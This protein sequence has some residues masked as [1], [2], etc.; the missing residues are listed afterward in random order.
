M[1]ATEGGRIDYVKSLIELGVDVDITDND[2][3]T[4]RDLAEQLDHQAIARLLE[5]REDGDWQKC[6]ELERLVKQLSAQ[7]SRGK[8]TLDSHLGPDSFADLA[9]SRIEDSAD[10][11]VWF[12]AEQGIRI[13][14]D[15]EQHL[16][17][18]ID[19]KIY[20]HLW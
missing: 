17:W 14:L 12:R 16:L 1:H 18:M 2:G 6:S 8:R 5:L 15:Q 11:K 10:N 19:G 4:A 3:M 20:E 7:L 13:G 9:D